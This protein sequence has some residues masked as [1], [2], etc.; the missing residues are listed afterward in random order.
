M[1][2]IF[3]GK[4]KVSFRKGPGGFLRQDPTEEAKR[5]KDDPSL[6][7]KSE[8]L[9][10]IVVHKNAKAVVFQRGGDFTDQSEVLGEYT[11]QFGKYKGKTFRWTLENDVAY[12]VWLFRDVQKDKE[13]G[14]SVPASHKKDS[15]TSFLAYAQSFE[16]ISALLKYEAERSKA[17]P[18]AVSPDDNLVGFGKRAKDTWK[19]VWDSRDDGYA[20]SVI[21]TKT[22]AGSR[23]DKL[24][25]YLLAQ[26]AKT[27][28]VPA[29]AKTT[30]VPSTKTT[31]VPA[32]PLSQSTGMSALNIL[33]INT[34]ISM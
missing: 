16:E 30:S 6:Q 3:P 19:Q 26:K 31:T 5:I 25:Q 29:K 27:P 23:M 22:Y 17:P 20:A 15:V 33:I 8:P 12:V 18:P 13:A 28:T 14:V 24:R 10:S 21:Q 2:Q 7:D 1:P 34:F 4:V 9:N 11:L 32:T